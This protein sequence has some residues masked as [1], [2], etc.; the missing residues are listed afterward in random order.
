MGGTDI[1]LSHQLQGKPV[2]WQGQACRQ[3]LNKPY[4]SE[5]GIVIYNPA[6]HVQRARDQPS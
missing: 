3:L 1:R 5:D 6:G 4:N 2:A